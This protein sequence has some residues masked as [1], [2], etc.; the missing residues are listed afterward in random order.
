MF[1]FE[2]LGSEAG[3]YNLYQGDIGT[4][5]SHSGAL[6]NQTPAQA[7]DALELA[8]GQEPGDHYFLVTASDCTEG[9]A[10]NDSFGAE[11][12]PLL[13]DCAP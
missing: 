6:C 4:W 13:L 10:G 1:T 8:H 12:D 5:Y 2:D 3:S 9:T 11:R 7:G